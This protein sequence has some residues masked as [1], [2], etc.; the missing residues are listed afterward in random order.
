MLWI[1]GQWPIHLYARVTT[2]NFMLLRA[3][4]RHFSNKKAVQIAELRLVGPKGATL[5]T[6]YN[7]TVHVAD[8]GR[9][10]LRISSKIDTW[11]RTRT[12]TNRSYVYQS[13]HKL[14][15]TPNYDPGWVEPNT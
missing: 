9:S 13:S 4:L 14:A 11:V 10:I 8:L 7:N 1:L 15:W 2:R 5:L 12:Q 6:G 3:I